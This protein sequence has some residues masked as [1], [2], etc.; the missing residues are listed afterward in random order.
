MNIEVIIV[1][2]KVLIGI[3]SLIVLGKSVMLLM[4]LSVVLKLVV[5]EIFSVKGLVSGLVR[6]VCICVSVSESDVLIVMVIS[7]IGMWIF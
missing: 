3:M 1:M 7:V 6:M 2:M 5:V 4:R